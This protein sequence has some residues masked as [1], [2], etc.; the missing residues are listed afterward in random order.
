ML[1]KPSLSI[2]RRI[3]AA[4]ARVYGAWTEPE[5]MMRWWGPAGA[6]TISAEADPRTGGRFHVAFRTPDGERHDVSG[7]YKE[8][9]PDERLVFSWA[10]RTMPER[11]SQVTLTLRP[12]GDGTVLILTHEQFFDEPARDNHRTGWSG[13]LD[14]LEQS[15]AEARAA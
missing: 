5:K 9:V 2:R 1:T 4:P 6:E 12:D 15:L 8:V 3:A 10:W 13:A 14:R 7:I 11:E